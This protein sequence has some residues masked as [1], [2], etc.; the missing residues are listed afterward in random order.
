[1]LGI[2]IFSLFAVAVSDATPPPVAAAAAVDPDQKIRCRNEE[3]TGSLARHKRVCMSVAEWRR[4]DG[5]AQSSA[6][7]IVDAGLIRPTNGQ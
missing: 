6:E 7:H 1:M 4:R 3:I 5:D 2:A